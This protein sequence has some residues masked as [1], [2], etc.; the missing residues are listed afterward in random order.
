MKDIKE[1]IAN[2]MDDVLGASVRV[3]L[4]SDRTALPQ[5]LRSSYVYRI[6]NILNK[7]I[8]LV[9]DETDSIRSVAAISKHLS[10]IRA[11]W[12]GET[13]YVNRAVTS[14]NRKR[15]IDKRIPFIVPGNQ[16]YLPEMGIDLREHFLQVRTKRDVFA[17]ATQVLLLYALLNQDYG[18]FSPGAMSAHLGYSPMTMTRAFD[19]LEATGIGEHRTEGKNRYLKLHPGGRKLWDMSLPYLISPVGRRHYVLPNIQ[20]DTGMK[21]GET[22]LAELTNLSY[23]DNMV[24]AVDAKEWKKIEKLEDVHQ[25]ETAEPNA[26]NVEI[27]KYPPRKLSQSGIVDILSLYLSLKDLQDERVQSALANIIGS[28]P[29]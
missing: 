2:Y 15:L 26:L 25:V 17:P 6:M 10:K 8:L 19:Q 21:A 9:I 7:R 11:Y 29:W 18:E 1:A 3:D 5:Y 24:I 20:L 13:V 12:N 28:L 27:W 4:W 22:A 16:L 14:Y 23:P